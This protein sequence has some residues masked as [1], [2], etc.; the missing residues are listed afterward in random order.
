MDRQDAYPITYGVLGLLAFLGPMSGYDVKQ[1]FDVALTPIW[2]ATHSQ[3][4]TEL[5][6]MADLGWVSMQRHYQETRPDRKV[7][8]VTPAGHTALRQWHT[9]QPAHGLHMRDEVL[10]RFTFGAFADPAALAAT[11]RAAIADHEQRVAAYQANQACLPPTPVGD[12]AP[13]AAATADG[14]D[15]F[16]SEMARFGLL[17]EDMYL[18]WLREALAS[19]EARL[20]LAHT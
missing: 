16:F 2:N 6:R 8:A 4:Y 18:G 5:R 3:V 12:G 19:V 1:A 9:R 17:L 14:P 20:V 10:L 11:L 15:P 7:Y 13:P